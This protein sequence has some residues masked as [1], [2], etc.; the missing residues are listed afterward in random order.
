MLK[1]PTPQAPA[2]PRGA[3]PAWADPGSIAYGTAAR[4]E[5]VTLPPGTTV[6]VARPDP[7]RIAL[8][9]SVGGIIIAG[10]GVAPHPTPL[11]LGWEVTGTSFEN[12]YNLFQYG[13]LVQLEWFAASSSGGSIMVYEVYRL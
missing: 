13:P 5:T 11:T 4:M 3:V 10:V 12:W 7:T 1:W 2:G 9:F 6:S 8:G